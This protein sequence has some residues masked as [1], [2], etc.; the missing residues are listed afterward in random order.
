MVNA[1]EIPAHTK[2]AAVIYNFGLHF[3]TQLDPP[4]YYILL[5]HQ[6]LTLMQEFPGLPILWRSTGFTHFEEKHLPSKWNCRTPVR[7]QILNEISDKLVNALGL[8]TID[9][10]KL[11]AARPDATPDNRHYSLDNVRAS[12]NSLLLTKLA[13]ILGQR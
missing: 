7:I 1:Q 6:F 10:Q 5:R 2:P 9:F 8:H 4:L 11:T 3:A 13:E 12:Y